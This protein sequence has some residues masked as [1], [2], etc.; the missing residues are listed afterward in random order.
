MITA[1][2]VLYAM[3][4]VLGFLLAYAA[5]VFHVETNPL[6]GE[7][8]EMLPNTH[9]GQCGFAGCGAAAEAMVDGKVEVTCCPPGGKNVA[10]A[11]AT[12]LGI[13]LDMDDTDEAPAFAIINSELCTGCTRCFKACPTDAIIGATKQMHA[14][15]R[16]ACTGCTACETACPEDCISMVPDPQTIASWKWPKPVAA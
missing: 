8:E 9:C 6:I 7:V 1:A 5:K 13:S 11:I 16:Q 2:I 3:G 10:T 12:K 4:L 14:V 15:I